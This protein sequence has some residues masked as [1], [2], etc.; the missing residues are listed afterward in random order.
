[1]DQLALQNLTITDS[2]S[3]PTTAY[4]PR[5]QDHDPSPKLSEEESHRREHLNNLLRQLYG[6]SKTSRSSMLA[7][8]QPSY[9][10]SIEERMKIV[11]LRALQ[12]VRGSL[13]CPR[14]TLSRLL[15]DM[16]KRKPEH[17]DKLLLA[18]LYIQQRK[19]KEDVLSIINSLY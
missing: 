8:P 1:M 9:D 14:K 7:N 11:Q 16:A 5:I 3:P 10:L 6:P 2:L 17:R 15:R 13:N 4:K 19:N 12:R 18:N